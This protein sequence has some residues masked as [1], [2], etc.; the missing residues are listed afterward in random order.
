MN[1]SF[2]ITYVSSSITYMF[3][4]T[5][6]L[7]SFTQNTSSTPPV[8][9]QHYHT[10]KQRCVYSVAVLPPPVCPPAASFWELLFRCCRFC[11]L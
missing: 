4:F 3:V 9:A 11:L 10:Q 5:L 1:T 2:R 7:N 8:L 6:F